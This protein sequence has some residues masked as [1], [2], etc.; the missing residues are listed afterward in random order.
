[1]KR[2]HGC[3]SLAPGSMVS[4]GRDKIYACRIWIWKWDGNVQ[5]VRASTG[6]PNSEGKQVD[7][8]HEHANALQNRGEAPEK[9]GGAKRY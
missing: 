2:Q 9:I 4:D 1:M 7:L 3:R 5:R 6:T 8:L